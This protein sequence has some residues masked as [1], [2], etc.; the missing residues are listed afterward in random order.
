MSNR[1]ARWLEQLGLADYVAVFAENDI[2]WGLLPELD[3]ESLKE[4]GIGH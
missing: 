2:D 1:I 4:I 3:Q